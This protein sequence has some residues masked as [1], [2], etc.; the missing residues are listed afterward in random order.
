[1]TSTTILCGS[2]SRHPVSLGAAMHRAGYAALG[3]DYAYVPFECCDLAGA[4]TGMRALGI[5]GFGV[6]MP[7]KVEILPLLDRVDPL[8][9]QI[10]AVNTV[11]NDAG[12]LTGHNTDAFGAVEAFREA[13]DPAGARVVV[14]GAGGAARAVAFGLMDAGASVHVVNRTPERASSLARAMAARFGSDATSGGLDDLSHLE[15]FDAV[16]NAS[17]A[18]MAEYGAS[19]VPTAALR[20]ALLVMDIVYEPVETELLARSRAAGATSVDGTRMLLHQAR[21]QFELYT[22]EIAPLPEIDSALSRV[23]R[24]QI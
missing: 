16:V 15:P 6:S 20:P 23:L 2:L 24:H 3:L 12:V 22:L 19:P 18:G 8:A 21:R 4:L 1:M 17:A 5:R 7:F 13:R 11:V 14:I 9:Q 10:G